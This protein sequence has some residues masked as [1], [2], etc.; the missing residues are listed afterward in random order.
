MPE[1]NPEIRARAIVQHMLNNDAFSQWLG[2]EL[3]AAAPG[4]C[5]LKMV[6]RVEM[7]NGFAI[8]HGGITYALADSALA[9]AANG[10]GPQAVSLETSISHTKPLIAGDVIIAEAT[11][12]HRTH[13]TG[14]YE[15][16]V[17][18]NETLVAYFKGTV[19][20]TS[21]DWPESL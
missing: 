15:V 11:E 9:F 12:I 17:H 3:M 20:I 5:T 14:L 10:Y 1:H 16:R 4:T 18:K 7:T 6:V 13:K 2:I 21:K 8:A 19:F